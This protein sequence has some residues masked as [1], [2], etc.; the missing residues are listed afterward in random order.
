MQLRPATLPGSYQER[1]TFQRSSSFSLR[2]TDGADSL[3]PV[4]F[5]LAYPVHGALS[6]VTSAP[7]PAPP[8]EKPNQSNVRTQCLSV[9]KAWQ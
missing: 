9:P 7:R 8:A 1:T 2:D 5:I 6:Y 3:M 4:R